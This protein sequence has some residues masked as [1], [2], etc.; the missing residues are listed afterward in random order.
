VSHNDRFPTG[1]AAGLLLLLLLAI[2]WAASRLTV[3]QAQALTGAGTLA[4]L[5]LA[6]WKLLSVRR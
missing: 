3:E 1:P 4:E 2:V 6:A 5:A